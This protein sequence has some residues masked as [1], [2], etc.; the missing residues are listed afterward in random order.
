MFN[1]CESFITRVSLGSSE[2]R[3]IMLACE[4]K[5]ADVTF[6]KLKHREHQT[7]P[8]CEHQAFSS[9]YYVI[10]ECN[11]WSP[12]SYYIFGC[13]CLF[14]F[15]SVCYQHSSKSY[16]YI[17]RK[18]YGGVQSVEWLK[19][20]TLKV[21]GIW[22]LSCVY[23]TGTSSDCYQNEHGDFIFSIW[24]HWRTKIKFCIESRPYGLGGGLY[25]PSDTF[26][27]V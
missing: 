14:V 2:S 26:V 22:W 10:V 8:N 20:C 4:N 25:S 11:L 13:V 1:F 21:L 27:L 15:L 6:L 19:V 7:Y 23:L 18:F 16:E 17:A 3:N 24:V 12:P 5:T 9:I